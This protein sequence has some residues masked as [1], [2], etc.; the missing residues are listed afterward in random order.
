MIID[1]QKKQ[2]IIIGI[3]L[4]PFLLFWLKAFKTIKKRRGFQPKIKVSQLSPERLKSALSQV[5]E[6]QLD[7]DQKDE[8]LKWVRCPFSGKIYS[9]Q[10]RSIVDLQLNGILWDETDPK[11]II[12]GKI[13]GRGE[14]IGKYTVIDIE[15]NKVSL[16]DGLE[17]FEL[18]IGR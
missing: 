10:S 6:I 12:N 1:K 17:T 7:D 18:K 15:K 8:S 14:A 11:A 3:L 2:I 9:S 4:I 5:Q 13:R 16:S